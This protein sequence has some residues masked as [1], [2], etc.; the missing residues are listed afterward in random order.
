[1]NIW[2]GIR[3]PG[4][5]IASRQMMIRERPMHETEIEIVGAQITKGLLACG[6][7]VG[8]AVFVIPQLGCDPQVL[9]PNPGIGNRLQRTADE[10]LVPI[11]RGA[12]RVPGA[13]NP[14]R[15]VLHRRLWGT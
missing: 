7:D 11:D 14:P 4:A 2:D 6:H 10:A 13:P 5:D 3:I 15:N 1:M 9:P 12:V 8:F